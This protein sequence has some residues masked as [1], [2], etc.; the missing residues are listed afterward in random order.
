M[1]FHNHFLRKSTWY[2]GKITLNCF[3]YTARLPLPNIYAYFVK[4]KWTISI[5][6]KRRK[7]VILLYN[8]TQCFP[9]NHLCSKP[10]WQSSHV[11][12]ELCISSFRNVNVEFKLIYQVKRKHVSS[13]FNSSQ[14]AKN[15][16]KNVH[17]PFPK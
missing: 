11:W 13:V 16:K 5:K 1:R 12:L 3:S 9:K 7:L 8:N 2:R 4:F 14:M 10:S 6:V 15:E 17:I